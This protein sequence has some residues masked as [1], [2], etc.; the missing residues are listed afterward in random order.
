MPSPFHASAQCRRELFPWRVTAI[1]IEAVHAFLNQ[2]AIEGNA[3]H[4]AKGADL[5]PEGIK[6]RTVLPNGDE[7]NQL[8]ERLEEPV[9]TAV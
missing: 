7:L 5:P 2:K 3:V 4:P 1:S 8:I 9:S 6:E